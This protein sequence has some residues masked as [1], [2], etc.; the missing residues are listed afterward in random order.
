MKWKLTSSRLI[1]PFL[2]TY[3]TLCDPAW[4]AGKPLPNILITFPV[5]GQT[6]SW[7]ELVSQVVLVAQGPI[8]TLRGHGD[9]DKSSIPPISSTQMMAF[10]VC[11]DFLHLLSCSCDLTCDTYYPSLHLI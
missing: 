10:H 8:N 1:Q 4:G 2:D 5:Q 11:A 6:T 9:R 3:G 7:N